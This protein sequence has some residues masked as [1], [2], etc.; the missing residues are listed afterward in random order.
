M[1]VAAGADSVGKAVDV[2][3][4]RTLL[5]EQQEIIIRGIG[6]ALDLQRRIG[7]RHIGLDDGQIVYA[8]T[9]YAGAG[10]MYFHPV[11][12]Y[13]KFAGQVFNLWPVM[14]EF[15]GHTPRMCTDLKRGVTGSVQR[16]VAQIALEAEV[17]IFG[18]PR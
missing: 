17:E 4:H 9:Q 12:V 11:V 5:N 16:K 18:V 10:R 14:G 7:T 8:R 1:P 13:Q 2:A 6:F 15:H 3:T